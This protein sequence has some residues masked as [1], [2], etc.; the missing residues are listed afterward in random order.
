MDNEA[1]APVGVTNGRLL[2]WV[3]QMRQLCKPDS[4]HWAGTNEMAVY[5]P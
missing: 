5:Y 1:S 3:G 4:V 2:T